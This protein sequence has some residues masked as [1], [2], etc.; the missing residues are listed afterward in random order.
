M[1]SDAR[2]AHFVQSIGLTS[3]LK[4]I[5]E[6]EGYRLYESLYGI[7]TVTLCSLVVQRGVEFISAAK[8]VLGK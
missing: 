5:L 7:K 4:V 8:V 3:S 2:L 6:S 1:N